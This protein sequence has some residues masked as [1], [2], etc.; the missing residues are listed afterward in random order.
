VWT[1]SASVELTGNNLTNGTMG[2]WLMGAT[3]KVSC[4]GAVSMPTDSNSHNVIWL[5][6]DVL[7]W[8]GFDWIM[9]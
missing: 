3:G 7:D 9:V 2:V 5:D 1:E 8:F 4:G 6:V